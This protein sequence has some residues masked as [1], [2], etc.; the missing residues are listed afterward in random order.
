MMIVPIYGGAKMWRK[1]WNRS[2][3]KTISFKAQGGVYLGVPVSRS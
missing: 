3:E 1:T 2:F